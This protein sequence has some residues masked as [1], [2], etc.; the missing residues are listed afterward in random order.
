MLQSVASISDRSTSVDERRSELLATLVKLIAAD[1]GYWS[2]GNGVPGRDGVVAV[3]MIDY[4]FSADQKAN[5]ISYALNEEYMSDWQ[6]RCMQHFEGGTRATLCRRDLYSDREWKS[7][8]FRQVSSSLGMDSWI[9]SIRYHNAH[10]W[11]NLNFYR[12]HG[13]LEFGARE[14]ALLDVTM[15]S[16]PWLHPHTQEILPKNIFAGLS[17]RKRSV[18][19]LL[20]DGQSRKQVA[21]SLG[22]REATVSDYIKTIYRHFDV[23]SQS[24]L[25]AKFLRRG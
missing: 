15:A 6:Q 9:L 18:L 4:G 16:I 25:A 5:L 3:A 21:H 11:S 8:P 14:C 23:H 17:P 1:I 10:A 12:V 13:A 20:L 19:L 22:L 7:A 24:E 2:W